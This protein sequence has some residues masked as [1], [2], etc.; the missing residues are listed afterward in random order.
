MEKAVLSENYRDDA[1]K[2]VAGLYTLY[3]IALCA[4]NKSILSSNQ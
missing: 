4:K 3:L 1:Y 2:I